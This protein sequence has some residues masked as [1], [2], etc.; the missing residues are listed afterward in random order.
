MP[1]AALYAEKVESLRRSGATLTELV[2][3]YASVP[4]A[5]QPGTQ[6]ADSRG[7]DVVGRLVEVLSG[8]P[9]EVFLKK[10]IFE[11]LEMRDTRFCY[12]TDPDRFGIPRHHGHGG[13]R[14]KQ[15]G[16]ILR[17][18]RRPRN[19]L[20]HRSKRRVGG[21]I[22]VG[23]RRK[24]GQLPWASVHPRRVRRSGA[25]RWSDA[26]RIEPRFCRTYCADHCHS[27]KN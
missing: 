1:N 12:K 14:G 6:F 27:F 24:H 8:Q 15:I 26:F 16:R 22:P 7:T 3:V 21:H 2:R 25:L 20:C 4:L 13:S 10:R 9:F 18:G 19:Q 17:A 5:F 23:R 11:P